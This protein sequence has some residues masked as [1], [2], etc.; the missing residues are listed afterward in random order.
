MLSCVVVN[1]YSNNIY[2]YAGVYTCIFVNKIFTKFL[3]SV[4][5]D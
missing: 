3:L 4:K 5:I 1:I 2:N